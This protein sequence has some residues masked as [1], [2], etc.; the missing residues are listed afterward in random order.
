MCLVG[1]TSGKNENRGIKNMSL[2]S[3]YL[4]MDVCVCVCMCLCVCVCV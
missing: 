1:K 2:E 3:G 4:F